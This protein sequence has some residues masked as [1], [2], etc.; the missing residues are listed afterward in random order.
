MRR[1]IVVID[2]AVSLVMTA[3]MLEKRS[4][5][6]RLAELERVYRAIAGRNV[7]AIREVGFEGS[8]GFVVYACDACIDL[9]TVVTRA[10]ARDQRVPYAL[11]TGFVRELMQ[12]LER[13]HAVQL[14]GSPVCHG[15]LSDQS[16]MFGPTGELWLVGFGGFPIGLRSH[17]GRVFQAPEA[18]AGAPVTPG[19]DLYAVTLLVRSLIGTVE[20]PPAAQRVLQG[21]ALPEDAPLV[22]LLVVSNLK[23][24]AAFP[25]RRPGMRE[26][27]TMSAQAWAHLGVVPDWDGYRAWVTALREDPTDIRRMAATPDAASVTLPN[28]MRVDLS[29]HGVPR[30]LFVALME[31]RV[32]DASDGG[33]SIAQ[34]V[35]AAWPGER[36][37]IASGTNR[38]HVA[39]SKLRQL[40]LRDIIER[41][42]LGYRIAP[43]VEVRV[44]G[45]G[46]GS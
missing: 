26:G 44:E 21:R 42:E 34:L 6:L 9:E 15:V 13:V 14:A 46:D 1:H 35:A 3:P 36:M 19:A 10:S 4:A 20:L 38:V 40:G 43:G 32:R 37:S 22:E 28:G 29:R 24:L 12:T 41:V 39:L 31:A 27:L 23:I 8:H 11:A 25:D 17:A 33:M 2:G 5:L 30:Q 45:R 16:V 18:T 7:P